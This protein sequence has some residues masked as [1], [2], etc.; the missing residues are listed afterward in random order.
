MFRLLINLYIQ[1]KHH[2]VAVSKWGGGRKNPNFIHFYKHTCAYLYYFRTCDKNSYFYKQIVGI[3]SV[4]ILFLFHSLDTRIDYLCTPSPFHCF[5]Y[6]CA[7]IPFSL[8]HV[9][10]L[11]A[12]FH[13]SSYLC[14]AYSL[15]Q[16]ST[17]TQP[18]FPDI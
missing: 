5:I 14:A 2:P 8:L 17:V 6:L 3:P 7:A 11:S 15:T 18:F 1:T 12:A 16:V 13:Y 4:T 9:P 10:S